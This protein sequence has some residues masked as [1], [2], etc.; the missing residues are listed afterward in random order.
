MVVVD[1]VCGMKI[2][3]KKLNGKSK[4][5]YNGTTYY[6]C[7]MQCWAQFTQNPTQFVK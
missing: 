7:C 5:N 1:P 2:E 4:A 3:E 6:F